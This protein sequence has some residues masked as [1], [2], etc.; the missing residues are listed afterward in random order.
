MSYNNLKSINPAVQSE[1]L[2]AIWFWGAVVGVPGGG[3]APM[4]NN[5]IKQF[6]ADLM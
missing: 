6:S 1:L 2:G 4:L 3:L 5:K